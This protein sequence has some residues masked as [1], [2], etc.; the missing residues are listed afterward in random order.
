KNGARVEFGL[1]AAEPDVIAE[2]RP[3][4]LVCAGRGSTPRTEVRGQDNEGSKGMPRA[5]VKLHT[6]N[7]KSLSAYAWADEK[8]AKALGITRQAIQYRIRQ[9]WPIERVLSTPLAANATRLTRANDDE[10]LDQVVQKH[11]KPKRAAAPKNCTAK[12][13]A[14]APALQVIWFAGGVQIAA[15]TDPTIWAETIR[16]STLVEG[17]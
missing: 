12:P 14:V 8:E 11:T 16:R 2:A 17:A 5:D 4:R 15:S 1:H 7:G 10:Q 3:M 13:P 6:Y 9:G